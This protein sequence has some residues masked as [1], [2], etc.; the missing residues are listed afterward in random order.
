MNNANFEKGQKVFVIYHNVYFAGAKIFQPP[1]PGVIIM[2]WPIR[3]KHHFATMSDDGFPRDG[4]CFWFVVKCPN[5]IV[6][7]LCPGECI[8]DLADYIK[9]END[10]LNSCL[11]RIGERG[12][13]LESFDSLSKSLSKANKYLT[14]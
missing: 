2:R 5:C 12:Y 1:S 9:Q 10:F 6:P 11:P 13:S 8:Y 14:E 3:I 4:K 7:F